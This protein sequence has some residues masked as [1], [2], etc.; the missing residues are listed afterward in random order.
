MS[1][2]PIVASVGNLRIAI[3]TM[4]RE[5]MKDQVSPHFGRAPT[6]TIVDTD[7]SSIEIVDN[8][9]EHFGGMGKAPA[10]ISGARADAV[11]CSGIGPRAINMF[12]DLGIRVFVGAVGQVGSVVEAL[13]AGT[14]EEATDEDACR[15]HRR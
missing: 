11:L 8:V 4:G 13:N 10:I 2:G 7:T 5:G 9:S 6:F 12:E 3:P 15:Q 14:L 1:I